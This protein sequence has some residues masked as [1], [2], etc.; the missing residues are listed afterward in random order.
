[1]TLQLYKRIAA[2]GS[3]AYNGYYN[4]IDFIIERYSHELTPR[5]LAIL[6][7][8]RDKLEDVSINLGY[9]GNIFIVE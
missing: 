6:Q 9:G 1:M 3:A 7:E 5:Q 2:I 4:D 8:C